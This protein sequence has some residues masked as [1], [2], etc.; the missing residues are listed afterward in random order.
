ML[1]HRLSQDADLNSRV[2]QKQG[3]EHLG[4]HAAAWALIMRP[5]HPLWKVAELEQSIPTEKY[6]IGLGSALDRSATQFSECFEIM[7]IEKHYKT[8]IKR[9]KPP[10]SGKLGVL[11]NSI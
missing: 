1:V 4:M 7:V 3:N 11:C 9:P 6:R 2:I 8:S 5:N 10:Q